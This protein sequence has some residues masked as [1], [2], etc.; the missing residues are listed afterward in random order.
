MSIVKDGKKEHERGQREEAPRHHQQ[1]E[2]QLSVSKE[3]GS[4]CIVQRLWSALY[5]F[6]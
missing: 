3:R 4:L 6:A 1:Y 5:L 2:T